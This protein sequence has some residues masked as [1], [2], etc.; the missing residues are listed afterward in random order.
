VEHLYR[1]DEISVAVKDGVA[2]LVG[3]VDNLRDRRI[4][5]KNAYEGGAREVRN[6]LQIRHGRPTYESR[7]ARWIGGDLHEIKGLAP[8]QSQLSDLN[9]IL[10]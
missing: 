3:V 10:P 2:T 9:R 5:T 6:F 8:S 1:R 4:A 7:S